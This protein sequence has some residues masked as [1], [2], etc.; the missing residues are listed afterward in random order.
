[1][2]TSSPTSAERLVADAQA[3][4]EN[5]T[6]EQLA[7]E[8]ERGETVLVD[9]REHAERV[10]HGAIPGDVHIP[11]GML[12]FC[13]D[14]QLP[15]H[16]AE[17]EPTRRIVLYCAKGNRSALGAL[18]LWAMGFSDVASLDGGFNG[19]RRAGGAVEPASRPESAPWAPLLVQ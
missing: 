18:T 3:H 2:N 16:A 15:I 8:L 9:L 4:V 6:V 7:R 14:P 19:W 1:M 13:A 5:L 10:A 12:E 17:L 11:R